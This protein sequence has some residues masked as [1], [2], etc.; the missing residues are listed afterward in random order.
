MIPFQILLPL[1]NSEQT[2]TK[3]C[4]LARKFLL[5]IDVTFI[6]GP[7]RSAQVIMVRSLTSSWKYPIYVAFDSPVTVEMYKE[8]IMELEQIGYHVLISACDQG[9]KNE[10]LAKQLGI[11]KDKFWIQNPADPSR[12][13]LWS[14]DFVHVFK[15]DRNHTFDQ[16]KM[17][18]DGRCFSKQDFIGN[19]HDKFVH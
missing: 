17:L 10:G 5:R 4:I 7:H 14:H 11:T 15:N 9:S 3:G 19:I 2:D 12:I 1:D 18:P 16:T 8:I 6:S 13:V